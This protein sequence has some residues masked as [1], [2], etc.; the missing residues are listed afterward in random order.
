M[1]FRVLAVFAAFAVIAAVFSAC[2]TNRI[3]PAQES[4]SHFKMGLSRMQSGNNESALY[5]FNQAIEFNDNNKDAHFAAGVIHYR[6]NDLEGAAREFKKVL[7]IDSRYADAHNALGSIYAEKKEYEKAIK[8]FK[9]AAESTFYKSQDTALV[10]MGIAYD[11]LGD[12]ERAAQSF[13]EALLIQP[14]NDLA[15]SNLANEYF[16]MNKLDEAVRYY[17]KVLNLYPDNV[18]ANYQL[19]IVYFKMGKNQ[20]AAESFKKSKNLAAPGSDV[21]V[22]IDKYL[23]LLK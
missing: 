3:T 9:T 5:E 2:A 6:Q 1:K 7:S 16:K 19:G 23:E 13:R 8:E 21:A 18:L 20:E 15:M 14:D 22:S 12:Q 4:L 17:K 10:N 11:A